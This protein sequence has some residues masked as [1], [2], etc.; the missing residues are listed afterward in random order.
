MSKCVS[1][2]SLFDCFRPPGP[3]PAGDF[4]IVAF[5]ARRAASSEV[6]GDEIPRFR[7]RNGLARVAT[8]NVGSGN[9][10]VGVPRSCQGPRQADVKGQGKAT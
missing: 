10:A 2:R 5:Y 8:T 3:A 1:R 6:T 4:S 9:V 7:L